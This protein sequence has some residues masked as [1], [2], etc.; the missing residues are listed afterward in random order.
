MSKKFGGNGGTYNQ[1][2]LR[3][4][5]VGAQAS[6]SGDKLLRLAFI[7]SLVK[8]YDSREALCL[9]GWEYNSGS[10]YLKSKIEMNFNESIKLCESFNSNTSL[11]N[12]NSDAELAFIYT[13]FLDN[14][15]EFWVIILKHYIYII[16]F[17][18]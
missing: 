13:V 9:S 10:C 12:I 6:Y 8:Y 17:K 16:N 11:I 7:T 1:I 14:Y 4:K 18:I 2:N 5:L 15:S 3:G